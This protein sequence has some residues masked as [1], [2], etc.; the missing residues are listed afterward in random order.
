MQFFR[1]VIAL[2]RRFPILQRRSFLLGQDLDA[3]NVPDIAW[4]GTDLGRPAW[5]DPELR[6]LCCMLDGGETPSDEGNYSAL[7][8][9]Q[10]GLAGA[11][12]PA[13][14]PPR[15]PAWR[16]VLDTSLQGGQEIADTGQEVIIDP[17]GF[18]LASPR[19][20]VLLLSA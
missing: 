4:F 20:T 7:P 13:A 9:P 10:R 5:N 2:T 11:N 14:R 17:A 15:R 19:S 16:R 1:K 3:D 6:T 8:D 12:D 18:Y